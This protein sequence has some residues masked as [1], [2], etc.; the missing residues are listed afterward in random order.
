M[1]VVVEA[2][3]CPTGAFCISEDLLS[4]RRGWEGLDR[5]VGAEGG[6]SP[7]SSVRLL[8]QEAGEH[9]EGSLGLVG[10]DHVSGALDGKEGDVG[11]LLHEASDLLPAVP[12]VHQ[13]GPALHLHLLV[14]GIHKPLISH[15]IAGHVHIAIVQQD[16]VFLRGEQLQVLAV[17]AL[18]E[19]AILDIHQEVAHVP[20]GQLLGDVE[21][22][23]DIRVVE[24]GGGGCCVRAG[25][26]GSPS[27]QNAAVSDAR[28]A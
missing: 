17:H 10:G 27:P 9:G 18:V 26:P 22:L 12:V 3:T 7:W 16:P 28:S 19:T 21:G 1:G 6:W 14:E 13:P 25:G 2:G 15:E 24:V 23:P 11:K 8:I 4:S 5:A 20:L